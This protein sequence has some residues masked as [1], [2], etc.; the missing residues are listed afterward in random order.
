V[1]DFMKLKIKLAQ[2]FRCA[3]RNSMCVHVFIGLSIHI[4]IY[5][6]LTF[7]CV[8]KK[9]FDMQLLTGANRTWREGF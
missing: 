6:Y 5:E 9:R 4:Y 8:S 3:H 2:S 1:T 7:Y